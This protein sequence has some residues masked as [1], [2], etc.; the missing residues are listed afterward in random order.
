MQ[1]IETSGISDVVADT[2]FIPLYMR[3]L[4]TRMEKGLISDPEACR[5]VETVDYDFSKYDKS[6]STQVGVAIR[7]RHFDDVTRRFI[8]KYDNPVVVSLGCGLDTRSDR[9]DGNKGVF[10]NLDLPEVMEVRERLLPPNERNVSVHDSLFES[11]WAEKLREA[12]PDGDFLILAEGVLMYF[13]EESV[14]SALELIS[15]SL[16]PKEV[17]FDACTSFACKKSDKH[18]TVKHT[19][20]RFHWGLDDDRLP[21]TWIAPLR[22]KEVSYFMDKERDRWGLFYRLLGMLPIIAK[23]FRM[24]HYA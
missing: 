4:E 5:I 9:V 18:E 24:L 23:S 8:E 13:E 16:A 1:S 6:R 10:Y 12:H 20:A 3:C 14:R 15:R 7:A 2:L 17:L 21:E 11:T 19:K 22:L